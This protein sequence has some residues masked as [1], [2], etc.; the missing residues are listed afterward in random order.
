[1]D[2]VEQDRAFM[3]RA[4]ALAERARGSVE[5]NPMVGAV[6]VRD[7]RIIGEGYHRRFGGPHAEVLALSQAGEQARGATMY[8]TL[9][10]CA[11]H[12]KTPPCA[13]AVADAGVQRVVTAVIDPT[14]KTRGK[15]LALLNERGVLTQ[16]GLCKGD[17]VRLNAGFFKLVAVGYPLVTA[18]WAMSADGK[19]A[20]RTGSAR[21]ISSAES[22]QLVHC[23]RGEVDCITVGCRTVLLD[24]P[25]LTC[26]EAES[27]RVAARLVLCG[28]SVPP[29]DS[30]LVRSV[31]EAPVILAYPAG[32][33][34]DGL[35]RL[36]G[37]GC[38]TLAVASLEDAPRRLDLKEL[39]G[40]LGRR[41]MAN[42]LVEGGA[43][44]LGAF[45]DGGLVDKVMVF[46]APVVIGG[47]GALTAVAGLGKPTVEEALRLREG[48]VQ[49]VG[50]D[51]L[52]EGWA[53]D[54]LA[55]AP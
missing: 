45:F 30:R 50:P 23:L 55:W 54:P 44:V 19:I 3:Q 7:G 22:R 33:P 36:R 38:E 5:P 34:P 27:K 15:G 24:D 1:M 42:V 29:P 37:L 9:E 25:L 43:Q 17:A 31:G 12:G 28:G 46:V 14:E 18:K 11:H 2:F 49:A 21:W 40:E 16:V 35:G 48:R 26:R 41:E 39:L 47:A 20:T 6:V 8:V 4:L 51:V 10:P 32:Q 52:I 53:V 13:P